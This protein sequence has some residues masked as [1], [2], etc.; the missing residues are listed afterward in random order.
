MIGWAWPLG[1]GVIV[2]NER[3]FNYPW[4]ILVARVPSGELPPH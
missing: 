2:D 4:T 1:D 3:T